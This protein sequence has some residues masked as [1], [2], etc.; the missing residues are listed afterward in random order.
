MAFNKKLKISLEESIEKAQQG[1]DESIL[2][3]VKW[4]KAWFTQDFI[5]III[6]EKLAKGD[7]KFFIKLGDALSK[8][9]GC[10]KAVRK[11]ER[12][13]NHIK[14]ISILNNLKSLK[15]RKQLHKYLDKQGWFDGD[16]D[17]TPLA[18]FDAFTK[19]LKRQKFI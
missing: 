17:I 4:D 2:L 3:L 5:Q 18:V 19:F 11:H 12:L 9:P 1:D 13:L 8:L 15:T 14:L 7:H 16:K 6:T 10:M